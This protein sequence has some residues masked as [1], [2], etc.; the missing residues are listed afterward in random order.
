MIMSTNT[1][2][3]TA[4]SSANKTKTMAL[5]GVMAAVTCILGPLSVPIGQ[6]PISLTNLV[7]YF[8]VFVLGIWA[9]TGSYGIYL[10]LG[11]VGLPVFSGFAGGLGKLLG[12]TGGYL[13]GFIFMALIGGAVIE[14]SHRNIF[15]TML[16]WV[17][18]TAVAYA[19]GTVWFVYLM[20]CSVTYALTVCVFPFIIADIAKIVIG[21]ILGREVRKGLIKAGIFANGQLI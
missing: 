6:I 20:K 16:G 17:V 1:E 7:I 13:I 19:F 3:K 15:L 5:I 10:L 14:L 4:G 21:T 18:G 11:A 2:V 12:P 8:T 9:G